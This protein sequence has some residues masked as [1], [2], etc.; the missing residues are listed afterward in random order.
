MGQKVSAMVMGGQLQTNLQG[1]T[2]EEILVA[3]GLSGKHTAVMNNNTVELTDF[4]DDAAYIVFTKAVKGAVKVKIVAQI[5]NAIITLV[6]GKLYING[7]AA[8][9]GQI[10]KIFK[11]TASLSGY[12]IK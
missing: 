3:L 7:V 6:D 1:D 4:V 12:D 9:K 11:T 10:T 5:G 8:S 2:V